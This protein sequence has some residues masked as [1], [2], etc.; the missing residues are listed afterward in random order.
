MTEMRRRRSGARSYPIDLS[1]PE[2]RE[3]A[4][5]V[6]LHGIAGANYYYR[7]DNPPYN[8]RA[9]A[10][11]PELFVREGVLS[12]LQ[13]VN[14]VLAADD[15]EVYLFD[16]YRP[17][18]LQNYFHDEWVPS[19]LRKKNPDWTEEE[20]L[21]EVGNYWAKGAADHTK[22][23][24]LSPP[25][26]ATGGVV[27]LTLRS[28]TTKEELPMG[29]V[30]D[31]VSPISFVDHFEKEG[32]LRALTEDEIETRKNRRIL[33]AAMT[34]AGFTVNPNEWWH[35]GFGDQLSSSLLRAP[36]A[37]YSVMQVDQ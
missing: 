1:A 27:D 22:I 30:F 28:R 12:R 16:A 18:R 8:H 21:R 25:P 7:E 17:V 23:D 34:R 4:V 15:L 14:A 19:Y 26:H 33:Y 20:I 31:D 32:S 3:R 10:A 11:I 24:P 9:P 13:E 5:D 29:G 6:L 2:N 35:Y 36:H 37:V